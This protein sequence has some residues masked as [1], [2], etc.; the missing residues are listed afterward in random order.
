MTSLLS[1]I[2]RPYVIVAIVLLVLADAAGVVHAFRAHGTRDGVI[3]LVLP[4]YGLYRAVESVIH[5]SPLTEE[6]IARMEQTA[7]G[8]RELFE[9][10]HLRPE[11]WEVLLDLIGEQKNHAYTTTMDQMGITYDVTATAPPDGPVSITV[12]TP[13][14]TDLIITMSDE[15]RD[16]E[17]EM[18]KIIK[19]VDGKTETHDT[20]IA[21]YSDDDGSQFLLA[22]SLAWGTIVEELK[23][24]PTIT[25]SQ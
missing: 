24:I 9:A 20:P 11:I 25:V 13:G 4:P 1:F 7:D 21:D 3:A 16:Q 14:N 10:F 15:N 18:L 12:T 17:P 6:D 19:K 22:W 23:S 8:R 5:R 2:R